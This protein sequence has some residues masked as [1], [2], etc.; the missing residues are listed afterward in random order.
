M[1]KADA[2]GVKKMNKK[3]WYALGTLFIVFAFYFTLSYSTV[4][5][6]R[7]PLTVADLKGFM[8]EFLSFLCFIASGVCLICGWLEKEGAE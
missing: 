1:D 7:N 4:S 5:F 8:H 2:S 3:Q 6:A